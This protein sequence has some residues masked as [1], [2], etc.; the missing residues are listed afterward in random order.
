MACRV[1]YR[2]A[3]PRP[4][5]ACHASS[6]ARQASLRQSTAVLA[7]SVIINFSCG[8]HIL[9]SRYSVIASNSGD[10]SAEGGLL[11]RKTGPSP[12]EWRRIVSKTKR[13]TGH[14]YFSR[15]T[16]RVVKKHKAGPA[17]KDGCFYK[18]GSDNIRKI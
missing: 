14:E 12:S 13:N 7:R 18:L 15:N 17:C 2:I 9:V 16:G 4:I 10:G 6:A 3:P 5:T 1:A 11:R 8:F